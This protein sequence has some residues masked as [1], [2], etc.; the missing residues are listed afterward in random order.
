[1]C[2]MNKSKE[3]YRDVPIKDK[4]FPM[5]ITEAQHA[6]LL[7]LG[8]AAWIRDQINKAKLKEKK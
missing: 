7:A 5:R 3:K 6:K 8:G 1:M 2:H 4:Y